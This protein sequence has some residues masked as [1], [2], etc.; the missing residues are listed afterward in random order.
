[1]GKRSK[2]HSR[3][4]PVSSLIDMRGRRAFAAVAPAFTRW[5]VVQPELV[6]DAKVV[7]GL[8]EEF[9][10]NY[11][12]ERPD[13]EATS[14]DIRVVA[15]LLV[16]AFDEDQE[17]GDSLAASLG[18]Y[19]TFLTETAAWTGDAAD[20]AHLDEILTE[21]LA[22]DSGEPDEEASDAGL[23]PRPP[24]DFQPLTPAEALRDIRR[25][26]FVQRATRLLEWVG[27]GR[28]VTDDGLPLRKDF[29]AVAACLGTDAAGLG[30]APLLT[31]YWTALED[32]GLIGISA[33]QVETT[34]ESAPFLS[35]SGDVVAAAQE[36]AVALYVRALMP[37][38]YGGLADPLGQ[39]R[40][41]ELASAASKN[42]LSA[43]AVF[44]TFVPE[45]IGRVLVGQL[46]D[47][48]R[49]WASDGLV[50]VAD[51]ITV[52]PVLR[53]P[54]ATAI[55][56][57]DDFVDKIQT[58][59]PGG[60]EATFRLRIELH[61]MQPPVWRSLDVAAWTPLD[62]LNGDLQEVF[63]WQFGERHW[64]HVGSP[65]SGS[66]F[67]ELAIYD[68]DDP[69]ADPYGDADDPI[70]DEALDEAEYGLGEIME[71]VGDAFMYTYGKKWLHKVTLT[72][73]LP[74]R[75][76]NEL[77][78]CTDGSGY[79][80]YEGAD[81]PAEWPKFVAISQD[82]EDVL[83]RS[84]RRMLRLREGENI[85]PAAFDVDRANAALRG[86]P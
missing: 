22:G 45:G 16:D 1:V 33:M 56:R 63:G 8:V 84:M 82:P 4:A 26:A 25:L 73:V 50:T 37:I 30:T 40:S 39:L 46:R 35:G 67:T 48:I 12:R 19:V 52:P 62:R 81:G 86:L 5:I 79:S 18:F 83:Y 69:D 31:K 55:A 42:P 34:P 58:L 47:E 54:L 28:Q 71:K 7:L 10:V 38:A 72:E 70:L 65:R 15:A 14:L 74:P 75:P 61:G 68:P 76:R 53:E 80:P 59:P 44:D 36:L 32:S 17:L 60:T 64:F 41:L 29:P 78:V 43:A 85:D 77:P 27:D 6:D 20:L 3:M 23:P 51:T 2:Q 49:S 13:V 11:C 66:S 57:A 21:L 24:I 9:L